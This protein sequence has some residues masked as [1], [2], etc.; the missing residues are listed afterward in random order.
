[1][2][3]HPKQTVQSIISFKPTYHFIVLS[4]IVGWPA[5]IQVAQ[6]YSL[7]PSFSL[8]LILLMTVIAAPI[9]GAIGISVFSGIAYFIGKGM[10]GV[11]TFAETKCAIAWSN[12]TGIFS[13]ISYATLIAYFK[14]GWFSPA[15][16]N[17]PV[18]RSMAYI[19][20][21]LFLI[22]IISIGWTIY[23]LIQSISQV[24]KFPIWKSIVNLVL[25]SVVLW[26]V[27]QL[28]S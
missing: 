19:L 7:S 24:Q 26:G 25:V 4:A 22:Q 5:A 15:W 3:M 20:F 11:A 1:M 2:W 9:L 8:P 17:M 28:L 27:I 13:V 10:G 21:C 12:I 6:L 18:D 16:V 23:L 14:E